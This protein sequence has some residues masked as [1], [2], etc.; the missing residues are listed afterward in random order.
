MAELENIESIENRFGELVNLI[1]EIK[2]GM[3][4]NQDYNNQI[5]TLLQNIDSLSEKISDMANEKS[6]PSD[7]YTILQTNILEVKKELAGLNQAVD[8]VVNR[9]LRTLI[10]T[11]NEKVNRLE[12]L[13]NNSGIDQ[14]VIMNMTEQL[15]KNLAQSV[16]KDV[17]SL[18]DNLKDCVEYLEKSCK[19]I[20]EDAFQHLSDDMTLL[21]TTVE[22]TTDNLK[23]SIIDI[24]SR[25]QDS[26]NQAPENTDSET[27]T[28][29]VEMLKN[30]IYNLNVNT[31]QKF[32]KLNRLIEEM[33]I[34]TKL[35]SFARI[36]S[37]P[38]V[39]QLKQT[40]NSNLN[41][42]VEK[43]SYTLQ[44]SQNRDELNSATQQFRKEVYAAVISMLGNVSEFLVENTV[45]D[46]QINNFSDKIEELTSVTE[47]NNSG[48]NNIQ[49]ELK[50]LRERC[51]NIQEFSKK[52]T[53]SLSEIKLGLA[54]V[55]AKGDALKNN[56][57]QIEAVV[58]ECTQ[59]IIEN[60]KPDRESIKDM[61]IDIKKNIS[62]LQSGDEESDYTYSMQDIESDVAKIRIYLN[63]LGQTGFTVNTDD[64]SNE[65]NSIVVMVDSIKQ[66]LNKID[67]ADIADSLD[68][69]KEDVTSI[70]TRINKLLLTSDNSQNMLES[71][72]KEFKVLSEEIDDQLKSISS[73]NK[74]KSLEEGL[75]SVRT[76]LN[77]SNSYNSVINQSLI[78]L[79]EWV[80]NAGELLTNINEK[81]EK[82]D[83]IDELKMLFVQNSDNVV[84]TVKSM[85]D[86]TETT[87]RAIDIPEQKDYT[88]TINALNE[89]IIEQNHLIQEQDERLNKLDEKLSTVLEFIAKNSSNDISSKMDDIDSKMEKLNN[90]I[91]KLTA[92]VSE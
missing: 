76:A 23:R 68:K 12:I 63:E 71:T 22:K 26:L 85:L 24:F 72:L 7:E 1:A 46:S 17:Q 3:I 4:N 54:E 82:L 32:S 14:K 59:S 43:Y 88:E 19:T 60:S 49:I 11:L 77:E 25:I 36:N 73:A 33:D 79:A 66:Q 83:Y 45:S 64:F 78:M 34:F 67:E 35:E 87:I 61:L 18:N 42:I 48:Y 27:L 55:Q 75:N 57:T 89:K 39:G 92:F 50:D 84:S 5:Y 15:E 28:Q 51:T 37:M 52:F 20:S 10:G 41:D 2:S 69:M 44:T 9:D 62:I 65:L 21:G 16:N 47:L 29:N 30:G 86:E 90:S 8:T 91:E 40:L 56:N 70:S 58:K 31:E 38:A 6:K 81:Q 13:T 74:F 53:D 80:D